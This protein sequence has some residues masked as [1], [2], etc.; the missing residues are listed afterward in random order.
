MLKLLNKIG[1]GSYGK[2]YRA[3][4]D[5]GDLV[6]VKVIP[7][8]CSHSFSSSSQ[9]QEGILMLNEMDIMS[10]LVHPNLMPALSISRWQLRKEND[11]LIK[12]LCIV[13]PLADMDLYEYTQFNK[14]VDK[15]QLLKD[16]AKGIEFLHQNEIIHLDIKLSN[17]LV[18][19]GRGIL[20]DYSLAMYL[21]NKDS[22]YYP[23]ELITE[24]YRAPE[25]WFLSYNKYLYSKATDIWS[26]GIVILKI[27]FD[28]NILSDSTKAKNE[29]EEKLCDK[30]RKTFLKSIFSDPN[31]IDLLDG[32]LQNNESQRCNIQKILSSNFFI[33]AN[34]SQKLSSIPQIPTIKHDI[35]VK[36]I[37]SVKLEVSL[38]R[39]KGFYHLVNLCYQEDVEL[40]TF[41]LAGDLFNRL[42]HDN[43]IVLAETCFAIAF[44]MIEVRKLNMNIDCNLE[45]FVLESCK[46]II[47]RENLFTLSKNLEKIKLAYTCLRNANIY[48]Y[49]DL[50]A[51][52]GGI[53]SYIPPKFRSLY[54]E[55][56]DKRSI[57]QIYEEDCNSVSSTS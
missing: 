31:L 47:Y 22:K 38:E 30:V 4:D 48:P 54:D 20:A 9:F 8:V 45:I 32:I 10:K 57:E 1:E 39:Y 41:F 15:V 23:S 35:K 28:R 5:K 52:D 37:I 12:S 26:Y 17:C 34:K 40:E 49:I 42:N 29:I 36:T 24:T 6:A 11:E 55:V 3:K 43:Y 46:Y 19:L 44:K 21:H 53:S 14:F 51:W 16:I 18:Y 56:L 2:V 27:M 25:N 7:E 50:K 13:M 33:P